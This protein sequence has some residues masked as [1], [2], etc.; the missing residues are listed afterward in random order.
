MAKPGETGGPEAP[1]P[2][3]AKAN[4]IERST[5]GGDMNSPLGRLSRHPRVRA[6]ATYQF[7]LGPVD[8]KWKST[9]FAGLAIV[10]SLSSA[11]DALVAVALAG[12]VFVSVSLNAARGRTALGLV[13]T[14]LPFAVVGPFVG[15]LIDRMRSGRRFI[16][17]AASAGR[18][19]ACLMMASWIHSLLLFPAAFLSLVCSKTHAVA[20]ASLVPAAV[21]KP[22]DLVRAN[23]RLAVGASVAT[24]MAA[25]VGALIYKVFSS[26][27]L[28]DFDVL[29]FAATAALSIGL[30][31]R[32]RV[33]GSAEAPETGQTSQTGET[34]GPAAADNAVADGKRKGKRA[35]GWRGGSRPVIP[36]DV[37]LAQV[38]MAGMRAVAG[39]LTALVVFG[40]R[41]TDTPVVWYGLVAVA[42]VAGN[43]C[44]ALMA[45]YLRERISEKR[46]VAGAALLIGATAVAATRLSFDHHRPAA[47]LLAAVIGLAASVAKTAFDAIVQRETDDTGRGRL[48]ARFES[49]F[50][51]V[52]VVGALIPV[53]IALSLFSGFVLVAVVVLSTSAVFVIGV[54]RDRH[55]PL[56]GSG[57]EAQVSKRARSEPP[58]PSPVSS[59][60][61]WGAPA[62][63]STG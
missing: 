17:F 60:Q 35:S 44:G 6:A 5:L 3:V 55:R 12:S 18:L 26:K 14:V 57:S 37:G 61:H 41:R 63:P 43:F 50:Q 40:F 62:G 34:G 47:L 46:L 56:R 45:P 42:S 25:A 13:C 7:R 32:I 39:F 30:L 2:R 58:P 20:K 54:A 11:G 29:V 48:F 24:S 22:E 19:A 4:G 59:P 23:S 15:P 9:P 28:L 33:L 31:T 8:S 52:W 27:A 38:S 36:R 49:I 10:N 1:R 16:I 53:V 51:L 21:D